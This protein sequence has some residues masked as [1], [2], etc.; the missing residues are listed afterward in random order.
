MGSLRAAEG[1][2]DEGVTD[3]A[4]AL[5]WLTQT[6]SY[7]ALN[8]CYSSTSEPSSQVFSGR[9]E[10]IVQPWLGS[11]GVCRVQRLNNRRNRRGRLG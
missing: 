11:V 2:R 1:S 4:L 7:L 5:L 6:V 10:C 3:P 8:D 9:A